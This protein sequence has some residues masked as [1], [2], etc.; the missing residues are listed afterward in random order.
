MGT[1]QSTQVGSQ[2]LTPEMIQQYKQ[3]QEQQLRQQ[4][5]RQQQQNQIITL[6]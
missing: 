1:N 5:M 4:Q 6:I 3:L 2:Q